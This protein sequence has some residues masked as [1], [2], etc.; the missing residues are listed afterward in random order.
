M[1]ATS[2]VWLGARQHPSFILSL[3]VLQLRPCQLQTSA[4]STQNLP[5]RSAG[6]AFLATA[7]ASA[8][9]A[10]KLVQKQVWPW[11]TPMTVTVMSH[12]VAT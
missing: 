1:M 7:R 12:S 6:R 4:A 8:K 2:T 5:G 10:S 3:A 11:T 9:Q